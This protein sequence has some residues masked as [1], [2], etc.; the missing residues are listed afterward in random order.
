MHADPVGAKEPA[1]GRPFRKRQPAQR[2]SDTEFVIHEATR[3]LADR[4]P[5]AQA[6][7]LFQALEAG[8]H[9]PAGSAQTECQQR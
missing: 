9:H 3:R 1:S 6:L 5:S 7:V 8:L 4:L 2:Y